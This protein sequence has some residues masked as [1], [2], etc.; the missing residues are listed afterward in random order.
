MLFRRPLFLGY[1]GWCCF[2]DWLLGR[3]GNKPVWKVKEFGKSEPRASG[4]VGSWVVSSILC[5]VTWV[6]GPWR[7]QMLLSPLFFCVVLF[8]PPFPLG[9][10]CIS[11]SHSWVVVLPSPLSFWAVLLSPLPC[12][13]CC[14]ALLLQLGGGLISK[15]QNR[16]SGGT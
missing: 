7:Y 6:F 13:W 9:G 4:V 8:L 10:C 1:V 12:V 11:R 5:P 3:L 15:K 16:H 14:C 2:V